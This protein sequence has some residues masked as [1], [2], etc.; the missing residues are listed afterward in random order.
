MC[1]PLVVLAP[2]V[3]ALEWQLELARRDIAAQELV[4]TLGPLV[5]RLLPLRHVE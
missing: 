2:S 1:R 3:L 4:D 5:H